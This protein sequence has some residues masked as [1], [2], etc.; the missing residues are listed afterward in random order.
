MIL[1]KIVP[2][3]I[4]SQINVIKLYNNYLYDFKRFKKYSGFLNEFKN[5]PIHEAKLT[6]QYHQIEK[7]LSLKKPRVGFGIKRVEEL[8]ISLTEYLNKYGLDKTSTVCL[9]CLNE[10]KDFQLNNSFS[11]PKIFAEIDNLILKYTPLPLKEGGTKLVTKE[12]ILNS[13]AKVNFEDFSKSR[14]SI[15]NFAE[16]EVDVKLIKKAVKN[17]QKTPSVC[18][19]QSWKVHLYQE[20]D[21]IANVLKYQNGNRGFNE[22]INKLLLVTADLSSFFSAGER[23]QAYTDAGMFSM[24]LVYAL[25]SLGLGTCCLNC[26]INLKTDEILRKEAKINPSEAIVMMIAVGNLP[27]DLNVAFSSRK[28]VENML[29]LH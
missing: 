10:Y 22:E 26:S 6:F 9:N 7:G 13:S 4:R 3:K 12:E 25:H 14:H 17:A 28:D 20:K 5:Q 21:D 18:N 11:N 1:K 2:A 29:T 19:R 16:G 8:I 15:R 27:E 23:N 24:S